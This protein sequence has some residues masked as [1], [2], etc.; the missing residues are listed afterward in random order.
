[1]K[2]QLFNLFR[3]A[4]YIKSYYFD[5]YPKI[6]NWAITGNCNSKCIFCEVPDQLSCK[7]NLDITTQH[8]LQ[9]ITEMKKLGIKQVRLV[10]GEPFVRKDV[11]E[12]IKELGKNRI[13]TIITTNG[14][15]LK[16]LQK[17]QIQLLKKYVHELIISIE[18]PDPKINNKIRGIKNDLETVIKGIKNLQKNNF[19]KITTTTVLTDLNYKDITAMIKFGKQQRI[20]SVIFQPFSPITIFNNTVKKTSKKSLAIKDMNNLKTE[21]RKGIIAAKQHKINTNL[22]NISSFIYNYFDFINSNEKNT[23]YFN[24]I[25]NNFKCVKVCSSSYIDYDGS[26][27]P[28]AILEPV[29][30]LK[31]HSLIECLK[32]IKQTKQDI[33]KGRLQANCKFCFCELFPNIIFSTINSPLKNRKKLQIIFD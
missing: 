25:V 14:L 1:M 5:T 16:N 17:D 9:L 13:R 7:N 18:S 10:G 29:A 26:L 22:K 11:F 8:A 31:E 19:N 20:Y 3:C 6:L 24:K 32:K 2:K 23:F 12:I 30:N 28:C 27:K 21:I 15:L 4:F 33:K